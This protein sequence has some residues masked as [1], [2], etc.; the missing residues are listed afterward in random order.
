MKK[1]FL[2]LINILILFFAYSCTDETSKDD[3]QV[4]KF[5]EKS[6]LDT[7]NK[8]DSIVN[9]ERE[10][11]PSLAVSHAKRALSYSLAMHYPSVLVKANCILGSAYM[12]K[13]K[14]SS[15]FYYSE[16]FKLANRYG[17]TNQLPSI[18]CNLSK[19]YAA[20]LDFKTS[21]LLL[22]SA[23]RFATLNKNWVVLSDAYNELGNINVDVSNLTEAKKM[24]DSAFRIAQSHSL[25]SHMGI[26]MGGLATL[27][28]DEKKSIALN[29]Q[30]IGY[31]KGSSGTKHE[32][33][34]I[35]INIGAEQHDQDSTIAYS[36]SALQILK[37]FG[38]DELSIAAENNIAYAF[39]DKREYSQAERYLTKKAIP[40]AKQNESFDWL[41]TL[42]NTYSELLI[43]ENKLG[44]AAYAA[45]KA[46]EYKRKADVKQASEQ[47][48]LLSAVL[49]SKN[50]EIKLGLYDRQVQI[51]KG[52]IQKMSLF[53][54]ILVFVGLFMLLIILF[55]FQRIKLK[56]Q[57]QLVESA[58]Q[59]ISIEENW[60]DRLSIELHDLA[61]PL[62]SSMLYEI[63][64][65]D[66]PDSSIK[67]ELQWKL[68]Q[69]SEAIRQISHKLNKSFSDQLSFEEQVEGLCQE[70]QRITRAQI[71]VDVID[72]DEQLTSENA[73]HIIRIVQELL[74]NAVKYV[75]QGN[76]ILKVFRDKN[77]LKIIYS[78]NGKGFDQVETEKKGLGIKSIYER[79]KLMG[80]VAKLISHPDS[81]THWYISIPI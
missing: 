39:M 41:S 81:G 67:N 64:A 28:G 30:A 1:L 50:K 49:D 75:E 18:Y 23:K 10:I 48:R 22:D 51:Q 3:Q 38:I 2:F 74:S 63:E 15:F 20:T 76:I 5:E 58:K 73:N 31:M 54:T 46:L 69:L 35:L 62:Y 80:G 66:L 44:E 61:S 21:I 33:A 4:N 27:E 68:R 45:R 55:L 26:A 47:V 72:F 16:G 12:L 9:V 8:L 59:I 36:L 60:A 37:D 17:I 25:Y 24:F 19:I 13:V 53:V 79:T 56:S 77:L 40:L 43:K 6:A 7:L 42:Y 78:D 14:D 29:K 70:M 52:K 57:K 71:K 32:I 34:S 65:I 11:N